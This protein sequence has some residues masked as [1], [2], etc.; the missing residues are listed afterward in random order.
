MTAGAHLAVYELLHAN[1]IYGDA[2]GFSLKRSDQ[3]STGHMSA[4]SGV[5]LAHRMLYIMCLSLA[6]AVYVGD[7]LA[8]PDSPGSYPDW[9]IVLPHGELRS[10]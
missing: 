7:V 2:L 1:N 4:G 6:C 5:L 10:L 8:Q 9:T 3:T